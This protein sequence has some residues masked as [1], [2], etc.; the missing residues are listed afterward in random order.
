MQVRIQAL[1][2]S[3]GSYRPSPFTSHLHLHPRAQPTP[4][5]GPGALS[6]PWPPC[7]GQRG[8][9][10]PNLTS[11]LPVLLKDSLVSTRR[12]VPLLGSALNRHAHRQEE[13][14]AARDQGKWGTGGD[15]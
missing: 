6:S 13:V 2:A 8:L 11:A 10:I 3:P 4:L 15:G 1:E 9:L 5:D 12:R 7:T 14:V